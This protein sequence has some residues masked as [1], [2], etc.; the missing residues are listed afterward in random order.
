[1]PS[2]EALKALPVQVV[3]FSRFYQAST[4]LRMTQARSGNAS[5]TLWDAQAVH[6]KR[7]P[8]EGI[9]AVLH[10]AHVSQVCKPVVQ[11]VFPAMVLTMSPLRC[12]HYLC[13]WYREL[14]ILSWQCKVEQ[15]EVSLVRSWLQHYVWISWLLLR[16]CSVSWSR[17]KVLC[18][19]SLSWIFSRSS[20]FCRWTHCWAPWMSSVVWLGLDQRQPSYCGPSVCHSSLPPDPSWRMSPSESEEAVRQAFFWRHWDS[21]SYSSIFICAPFSWNRSVARCTRMAWELCR[22]MMAFVA[23]FQA[24]IWPCAWWVEHS[25]SFQSVSS[26]SAAGLCCSCH[27]ASKQQRLLSYV[28]VPFWFCVSNQDRVVV[29][30]IVFLFICSCPSVFREDSH[31]D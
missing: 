4:P 25:A 9:L 19:R 22:W 13:C 14:G 30:N 7:V 15:L 21:W 12:F 18:G 5:A 28:L 2:A 1:M 27:A 24:A 17:F 16:N 10:A 3:D 31:F 8:S 20:E 29:S 26:L 6:R 11:S 23:M